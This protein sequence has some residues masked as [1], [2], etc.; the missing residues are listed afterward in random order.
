MQRQPAE[1][2]DGNRE[3]E[4]CRELPEKMGN[5]S[6]KDHERKTYLYK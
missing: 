5:M 6:F 2:K 3:G 1:S 4:E